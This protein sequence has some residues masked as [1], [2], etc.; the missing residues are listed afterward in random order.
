M[1]KLINSIVILCLCLAFGSMAFGEAKKKKKTYLGGQKGVFFK[2]Y[3]LNNDG[4]ISKQ[5]YLSVFNSMDLDKDGNLDFY[6]I[7]QYYKNAERTLR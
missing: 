2:K 7:D 6:E 1:K 5:E 3:D 4:K